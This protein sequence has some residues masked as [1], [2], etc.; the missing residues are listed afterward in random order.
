MT[1]TD[2]VSFVMHVSK[3]VISVEQKGVQYASTTESVKV[4]SKTKTT[5]MKKVNIFGNVAVAK[6]TVEVVITVV[7][8]MSIGVKTARR[9]SVMSAGGMTMT[10]GTPIAMGAM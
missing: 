4:M 3:H 7:I 5:A 6:L 9:N 1:V 10:L 8:V 2:Q